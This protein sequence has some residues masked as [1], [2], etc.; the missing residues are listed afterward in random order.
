MGKSIALCLLLLALSHAARNPSRR[1]KTQSTS[2]LLLQEEAKGPMCS[3]DIA[4]LLDSSEKATPLLFEK[5]RAFVRIFAQSVVQMQT[6]GW[7]LRVRLAALQYSTSVTVE[8]GFGDWRDLGT[9]H[10]RVGR[11]GYMGRGSSSAHALR[12]ATELFARAAESSG[13]RVALLMSTDGNDDPH[14]PSAVAA[15]TE[16]KRAGV[17]VFAVGLSELARDP[18]N[19]AKLRA[20]A[21]APADDH[22]L[23]L[24][25]NDLPDRLLLEMI[26]TEG[27]ANLNAAALDLHTADLSLSLSLSLWFGAAVVDLPD[28]T[29]KNN[30]A[31]DGCPLPNTCS[32][33][34]GTRGSP[35]NQGKKGDEGKRG[36]PGSKGAMGEH[37]LNGLQGS[38]G[39]QGHPGGRGDKGQRGE[40][41]AP[42]EKG[43]KGPDGPAGPQG[44]RGEQGPTGP[45]GDQGPPGR[46]GAKGE[47]GPTWT[48][49]L[50]TGDR[51]PEWGGG[52]LGAGLGALTD[53][54]MNPLH[55]DCLLIHCSKCRQSMGAGV[56]CFLSHKAPVLIGWVPVFQGDKGN[57]GRTGP[58][59]PVGVGELGLPGLPGTPGMQGIQ[60]I[61]GEGLP[62]PK[63]DRGLEGPVGQRGL[64]GVGVKGDKGN[65]G[66]KGLPGA[67]GLPGSGI[68]GEK[69]VQGPVGPPGSRGAPGVGLIGPKGNHGIPGEPGM[70]G[71]RG[72]GA[73]GIKGEPGLNGTAGFPGIP[74][75]D[76]AVGQ[77]G[78]TGLPGPRGPEGEP[79]KG[80]PGEKGDRGD[81]GH[82]GL[83]GS[84]GPVGPAGAKGEPGILGLTGLPG[85]TGRSLAGTKG[86]PGPIG[87][88]GPVGE[89]GIGVTGPKGDKGLPGPVGPAGLKGKG[90]T[91][92]LGLPGL[93]GPAGE[94]GL[95]GKGLLGP[96]GNQG[97]PG[98]PGTSGPPGV[99]LIGPS[100]LAG[101]PGMTGPQGLAGDGIQGPKGALGFQGMAG[102]RGAPGEGRL[103]SKGNRGPNGERGRKGEGGE[104]G[105]PGSAGAVGQ[106][107]QKGDP[108]LTKEEVIEIIREVCGCGIRCRERPLELVFVIDSSESVGPENFDL[109]KDFVNALVDRVPVSREATRVGVVLYSHVA[110][111]TVGLQQPFDADAVKA[112]VRGMPYVGEG[113]F[114][115]S[116]LQRAARVLQAGR[117]G[118]RKV[119][120]VITDGQTDRRD[121]V[122]LEGAARDAHAG[123]VEVFVVGV[124]SRRDPHYADFVAEMNAVATDPDHEHVYMIDDFRTLPTL[125]GKLLSQICEYVHDTILNAIASSFRSSGLGRGLPLLPGRGDTPTFTRTATSGEDS[126]NTLT[127]RSSPSRD[128]LGPPVPSAVSVLDPQTATNWQYVP[129]ATQAPPT[130]V[131]PG[132]GCEQDLD[133][134]PCRNYAVK[135]YYDSLANSCAQFWFGGCKGNRNRFETESNCIEA[136]VRK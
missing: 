73:L 113:T 18:A 62:G 99:G 9:F 11:M 19:A 47:R 98:V 110:T 69:G 76:G 70:P 71:M 28:C 7:R 44:A 40:R 49:Y 94:T 23:S 57:L 43:A 80:E 68:Q 22:V 16:A 42:G 48:G 95:E 102:P 74:G 52:V 63:G 53:A 24:T 15:A 124:V 122:D 50:G 90:S 39:I 134:G 66:G 92:P 75:E 105:N 87:P 121:A 64:P 81:R 119:A 109:V 77:K 79:G 59:G 108:G 118:V 104:M 116:A 114:T 133:P 14:S 5:Q 72:Q 30:M 97:V 125:E 35:G 115:G 83:P 91:G 84:V 37:G 136:C 126:P 82:R 27:A 61:P 123:G 107:G 10:A 21:S 45:A 106:A 46:E 60:G 17:R 128:V 31:R 93:P 51:D 132:E 58:S 127:E 86:D 130:R 100:G 12:N 117:P 36:L 56:L 129:D 120:V 88:S 29:Q 26:E 6:A 55:I 101:Q 8:Q 2:N 32:C 33:E 34:K 131:K 3:L 112:A 85:P 54:L 1:K 38:E 13:L 89:A 103:G 65:A 41:G 111:V 25:D 135:W 4:F 20:I 78:E 67:I 96:K